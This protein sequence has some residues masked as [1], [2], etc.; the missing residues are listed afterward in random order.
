MNIIK[1]DRERMKKTERKTQLWLGNSCFF[2]YIDAE[3]PAV[4]VCL[5]L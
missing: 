1:K 2:L 5:G 3:K 4:S